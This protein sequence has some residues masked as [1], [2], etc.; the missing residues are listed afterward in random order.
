MPPHR[1]T[2]WADEQVD[3]VAIQ[4]GLP[5]LGIHARALDRQRSRG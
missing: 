5:I 4:R 2:R 1:P 3:T